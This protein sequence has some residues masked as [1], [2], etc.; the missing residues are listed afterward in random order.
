MRRILHDTCLSRLIG[1]GLSRFIS[2]ANLKLIISVLIFILLLPSLKLLSLVAPTRH[3]ALNLACLL[4]VGQ[5]AWCT[6]LKFTY[7][8]RPTS[9]SNNPQASGTSTDFPASRAQVLVLPSLRWAFHEQET[10]SNFFSKK[11]RKNYY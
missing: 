2:S 6:I 10:L 9:S 11:K 4:E 1:R 7:Q 3:A 5:Q 8:E